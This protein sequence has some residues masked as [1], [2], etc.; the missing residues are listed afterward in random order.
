MSQEQAISTILLMKQRE[1][2]ELLNLYKFG[3]MVY[4]TGM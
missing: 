3:T 2:A 1:K 4:E